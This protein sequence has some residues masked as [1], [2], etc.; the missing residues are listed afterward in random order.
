MS[1]DISL[2]K[3]I[4]GTYIVD[5]YG[6]VFKLRKLDLE[7]DYWRA[8]FGYQHMALGRYIGDIG[9]IRVDAKTGEIVAAPSR[10]D[11]RGKIL[12]YQ[13]KIDKAMNM[14]KEGK[15]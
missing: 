12:E 11:V 9:E 5:N 14:I 13:R 1:V 15:I 4:L 3:K 10:E 7:G 6:I 2:V 8:V